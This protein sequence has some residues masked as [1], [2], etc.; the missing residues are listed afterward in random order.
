[1][2]LREAEAREAGELVVDLVRELRSTP[3]LIAPSTK[4]PR[5]ASIASSLRLRLIA[6][7][8][9]SA[10]PTEKPASAIATSS[11]WSWKTTTP[12]V[13][14]S[15]SASSGWSTGGTKPGPP[16]VAGDARCTGGRPCPGSAR[17]GRARP[18]RSGRRGSP[19]ACGGAICICARLSIWKTPMVSAP[20]CRRRRRVV[21]RDAREVDCLAV[22]STSAISSTHSS[23]AESIPSPSRSIF[24]KPASAQ[25]SLSHW[26][27]CRPAIAA[28]CTGTS[29]T[30]GRVEMTIP[31]GC[32]ETWRGRPAISGRARRT[33]ASAASGAS[34]RRP[35]A[36]PALPRPGA[37]CPR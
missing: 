31:P 3:V 35:A 7:R 27:I 36:T 5:N 19:A 16:G 32:C 18:G 14:R 37:G 10:S 8:R 34:C 2:R 30:S 23:T 25:E 21:E 11:T 22:Q 1:M 12:S 20:G 24:R 4:R 26:Q 33:R 17:A 15:G 29:S 9:P 6:R 28:G 13:S